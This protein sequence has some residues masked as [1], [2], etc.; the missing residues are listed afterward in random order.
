MPPRPTAPRPHIPLT[1]ET[2]K[3]GEIRELIREHGLDY[4]LLSD[5]ELAASRAAMFEGGE[6]REDVWLFAYGSLIWNPTVHF[7]EKRPVTVH[8]YHRKFCLKTHLGRGSPEQPGLV[9]GLDRGGCCRGVALRIAKEV[10]WSE[11]ELVWRREMVTDSYR[12]TWLSARSDAGA[13]KAIGFVMDRT[14]DR[15]CGDLGE[16]EVARMI[17]TATGFLGPCAE[18]LFNTTDHLAELGIPDA[19]LSRLRKRVEALQREG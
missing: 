14:T 9:L 13:I 7:V 3:T 10:A 4:R 6:I 12:P 17:A 19:G 16:E 11:L 18:Y 15:Y 8:G 2:I 1:R 5:E